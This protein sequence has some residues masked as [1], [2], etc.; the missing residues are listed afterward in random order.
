MVNI[1]FQTTFKRPNQHEGKYIFILEYLTSKG[2]ATFTKSGALEGNMNEANIKT[3]NL[4]L[5]CLTRTEDLTIFTDNCYV[6][7]LIDTYM[8]QWKANGFKNSKGE[9]VS[10]EIAKLYRVK[11]AHT[12]VRLKEHHSYKDWM[13][14]SLYGTH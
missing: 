14:R 9:P 4:A 1:Y 3:L 11:K 8:D 2:P 7:G 13:E 6:A 10:E 12:E 5:D